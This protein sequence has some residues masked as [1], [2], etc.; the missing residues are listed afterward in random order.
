[1]P[2]VRVPLLIWVRLP[3]VKLSPLLMVSVPVLLKLAAVVVTLLQ[4]PA[5]VR[6]L[7]LKAKPARALVPPEL[8]WM[9]PPARVRVAALVVMVCA[10][11]DRFR[12]ASST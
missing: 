6:V 2:A 7:V 8:L 4:V 12:F 9:V 10:A 3:A 1:M 5:M 11:P